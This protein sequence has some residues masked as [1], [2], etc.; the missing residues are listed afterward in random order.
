MKRLILAILFVTCSVSGAQEVVL[1][2]GQKIRWK[3]LSDA[4][5]SITVEDTLGKTTTIPKNKISKIT[6]D[7]DTQKPPL[8][9]ASFAFKK[10]TKVLNLMQQI[11]TKEDAFIGTWSAAADA[12]SNKGD[13]SGGRLMVNYAVTSDEYDL[14]IVV[15]RVDGKEYLGVVLVAEGRQFLFVVDSNK[16]SMSGIWLLDGQ[17]ADKAKGDAVKL[18]SFLAPRQQNQLTFMVRKDGLVVKLNGKD[19]YILPVSD[20]K[21]LSLADYHNIPREKVFGFVIGAYTS[22]KIRRVTMTVQQEQ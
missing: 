13:V 6:S 16:G 10:K 21:R 19:F 20:W 1:S 15:E 3:S 5:E 8:T 11:N 12:I 7:S 22:F 2:D 4:G 17:G 18:G 9:G 14:D